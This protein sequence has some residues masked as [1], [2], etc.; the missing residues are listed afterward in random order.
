MILPLDRSLAL[1]LGRSGS[2]TGTSAGDARAKLLGTDPETRRLAFVGYQIAE[3]DPALASAFMQQSLVG[4]MAPSFPIILSRIRA[5]DPILADQLASFALQRSLERPPTEGL[6]NL[7]N[8]AAYLFP[9]TPSPTILRAALEADDALREEYTRVSMA[10]LRKSLAEREPDLIAQGMTPPMLQTRR[11]SQAL[12]ASI[13]AVLTTRYLTSEFPEMR[14]LTAALLQALPKDAVSAIAMQMTTVRAVLGK[15]EEDEGSD[16][17]ILAAIAAEDFTKARLLIDALNDEVRKKLWSDA[18]YRSMAMVY[19]RKENGLEALSAA[20]KIENTE[21][22]MPVV[23]DVL[24][25]AS[26]TKNE[27]LT[28]TAF[29]AVTDRLKELTAGRRA[30][31]SLRLSAGLVGTLPE[32]AFNSAQK[33]VQAINA[34]AAEKSELEKPISYRG[35]NYWDDPDSY[36]ASAALRRAFQSLGEKDPEQALSVADG[37]RDNDLRTVARLAAIESVLKKG[38]PKEPA[39]KPAVRK[40]R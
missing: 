16:G 27:S 10:I 32:H 20:R 5:K 6:V 28:T 34:L 21:V 1:K 22:A 38:P 8:L 25:L 11:M 23:L 33:A 36:L 30:M 12:T 26:R 35:A 3:D 19:L 40:P 9:Y 29:Q 7:G 17:E 4:R 15:V 13:L 14:T 18:F 24:R 31:W 2:D 37:F 39:K